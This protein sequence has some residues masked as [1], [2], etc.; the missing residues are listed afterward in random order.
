ML[1]V[2]VVMVVLVVVVV[3]QLV[4]DDDDDDDD[5]FG[6]NFT[7]NDVSM[8]VAAKRIP[9]GFATRTT[10][11]WAPAT[12]ARRIRHEKIAFQECV[13]GFAKRDFMPNSGVGLFLTETQSRSWPR[14]MLADDSSGFLQ[15]SFEG[16]HGSGS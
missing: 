7:S 14:G 8:P 12:P 2:V 4:G 13:F 6:G 1:V 16:P 10:P 5:G 3:M 15:G 11:F 9:Q